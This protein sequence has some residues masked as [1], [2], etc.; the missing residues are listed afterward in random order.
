M[1]KLAGLFDSWRKKDRKPPSPD[2]WNEIKK[3]SPEQRQ[4][5][6]QIAHELGMRNHVLMV[7]KEDALWMALKEVQQRQTHAKID[8]LTSFLKKKGFVEEAEKLAKVKKKKKKPK[9][10]G[11]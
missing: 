2:V 8:A 4:E 10:K 1:G 6:A 5:V 7:N 3:L 9:S 11:G